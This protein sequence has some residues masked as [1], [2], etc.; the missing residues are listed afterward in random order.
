MIYI[1]S[2]PGNCI[3]CLIEASMSTKFGVIL[4]HCDVS[5]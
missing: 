3:T 4:G 1:R 5:F 2:S